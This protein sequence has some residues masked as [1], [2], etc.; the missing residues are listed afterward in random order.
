MPKKAKEKFDI[1]LIAQVKNEMKRLGSDGL[2]SGVQPHKLEGSA[3][4]SGDKQS[5]RINSA[6]LIDSAMS[7]A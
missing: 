4:M 3:M 6:V 2:A 1:F 5:D 7:Q